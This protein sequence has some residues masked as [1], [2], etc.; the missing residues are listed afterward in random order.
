MNQKISLHCPKCGELI[1][2]MEESDGREYLDQKCP[3]KDCKR[4]FVFQKKIEYEA[5]EKVEKK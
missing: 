2:K 1:T 3:N 4:V 5:Y